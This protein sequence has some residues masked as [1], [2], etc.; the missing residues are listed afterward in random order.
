[1]LKFLALYCKM[2]GN[3]TLTSP[4]AALASSAEQQKGLLL[5]DTQVFLLFCLIRDRFML[6]MVTYVEEMN[7][8]EFAFVLKADVKSQQIPVQF[9]S[10]SLLRKEGFPEVMSALDYFNGKVLKHKKKTI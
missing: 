7:E 4:T 5:A 10:I 2:G 9:T 3:K 6:S 8:C 1:M